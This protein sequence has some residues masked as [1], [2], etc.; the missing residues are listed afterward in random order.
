LHRAPRVVPADNAPV[1]VHNPMGRFVLAENAGGWDD[2]P[3][4]IS[5]FSMTLEEALDS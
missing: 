1:I 5:D 2:R 4:Q 3:G